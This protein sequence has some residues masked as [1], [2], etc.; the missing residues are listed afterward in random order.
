MKIGKLL[1]HHD[2]TKI[3]YKCSKFGVHA[4]YLVREYL[5]SGEE[6][7]INLV[8]DGNYFFATIC[9]QCYEKYL[10]W[11][12]SYLKEIE[13]QEIEKPVVVEELERYINSL[14]DNLKENTFIYHLLT[15]PQINQIIEYIKSLEE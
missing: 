8:E 5:W 1:E 12:G 13:E 10:S 7:R 15:N 4:K 6:S 2:T 9:G 14:P 11:K 3:C